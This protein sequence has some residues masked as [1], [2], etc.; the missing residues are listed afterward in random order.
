MALNR[1]KDRERY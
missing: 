1:I